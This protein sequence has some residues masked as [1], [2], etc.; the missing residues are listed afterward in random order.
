MDTNGPR[1][2]RSPLKRGERG[3]DGRLNEKHTWANVGKTLDFQRQVEVTLLRFS[4]TAHF[5]SKKGQKRAKHRRTHSKTTL[6]FPRGSIFSKA[7]QPHHV[8]TNN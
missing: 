4:N 7:Q 5:T 2:F 8:G 1:R 3:V 6:A